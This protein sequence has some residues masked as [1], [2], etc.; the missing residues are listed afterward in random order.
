MAVTTPVNS[1]YTIIMGAAEGT[2]GSKIDVW[3]EYKVTEQSIDDNKSYIKVYYYAQPNIKTG[4]YGGNGL[5]STVKVNGASGTGV[6]NGAYDFRGTTASYRVSW[7]SY[8]GWVSHTG[9]GS[10]VIVIE[11][12]FETK[13]SYVTGGSI[14]QSVE[15]PTIPRQATLTAA[16]NFTDEEN[17]T[18]TYT[19]PAGSVVSSLQA[20]ISFSGSNPDIAYRDISKTDT[21]YTFTLTEA[22]RKVLRVGT[23]GANSRTLYFYVKTVIGEST[24]YS[25]LAKTFTIVN[26]EPTLSPVAYDT[27]ELTLALTGDKNKFVKYYSNVYTSSGAVAVKEATIT[28]QSTTIGAVSKTEA[29][30]TF[31]AVEEANV[32]FTVIDNRNN[33]TT[34]TLNKTLINY[35][36]LT[37]NLSAGMPTTSGDLTFKISG[38]FFN[39]SFGAVTNKLTVTYK[40]KE[41][42]GSYGSWQTV[43]AT[44]SGNTYSGSVSLSGLNYQSTYTI[45]ARVSDSLSARTSAEKSVKTTPVFDWGENDFRHNTMVEIPNGK[46][47]YSRDIDGNEKNLIFLN[48][49]GNLTLG[50]GNYPPEQIF[51]RT[52]GGDIKL[53]TD[54][55]NYYSL[56]GAINALTNDYECTVESCVGGAQYSD[57]SVNAYLVGNN[58]RIFLNATRSS[59]TGA[60]NI[61]NE[62]VCSVRL[63][64]A[65]KVKTLYNISFNSGATGGVA[66]FQTGN[67]S[68]SGDTLEFTINLAA[69][70]VA[71]TSF[72]TF[73]TMPVV[74]NPNAY[75]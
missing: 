22:E 23:T 57:V 65:G 21:S 53:S 15:L 73:F 33:V 56:V 12:E 32:K 45:Q 40:I 74:I 2:N 43:T 54:G 8:S 9:D 35:V 60:G 55:T 42:D 41:N 4:S 69:V 26:P 46:A 62:V 38:N 68:V 25:K 3:A 39:G 50:G 29:T 36:K 67:N 48:N 13:S 17:P 64:H 59:A 72:T 75:V 71:T 11:G 5:Y 19:N 49:S 66:T 61:G 14:T 70:D 34:E 37:C 20:C 16:D 6:S 1:G 31:T 28:K 10:K 7:G 63:N 44:T 27:N 58:L 18:I 24:F 47:L 51:M 52:D 30:N